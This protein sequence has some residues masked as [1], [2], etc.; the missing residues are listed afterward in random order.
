MVYYLPECMLYQFGYVQTI[1]RHP[2]QSAPLVTTRHK[3]SEAY[4]KFLDC[5]LSV[6]NLRANVW[7]SYETAYKYIRWYFRISHS[8]LLLRPKGDPSSP[9]EQESLDHIVVELKVNMQSENMGP[10]LS[11]TREV[12]HIRVWGK[13]WLRLRGVYVSLEDEGVLGWPWFYPILFV[14]FWIN[15]MVSYMLGFVLRDFYHLTMSIEYFVLD[16]M[17][18]V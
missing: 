3:V 6:E 16:N 15:F 4:T 17:C 8:Y 11:R 18:S 7:C 9:Y 5:V 13:S 10:W 14:Y 1:P 2:H 12:Y